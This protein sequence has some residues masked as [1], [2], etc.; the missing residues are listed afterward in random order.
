MRVCAPSEKGGVRQKNR[1]WVKQTHGWKMKEQE[2]FIEGEG[3]S[4]EEVKS[5]NN[6][7]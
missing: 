2:L 7:T 1:D 5:E 4:D 3:E 6:S